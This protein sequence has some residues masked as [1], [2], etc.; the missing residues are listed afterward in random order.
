M[1]E[2]TFE[3][4]DLV[5]LRLQPYMQAYIKRSG[6][7]KLQSRFFGSYKVRRKVGAVAYELELPFGS[8]IHNVFNASC[9]KRELGQHINPIEELPLLD[10]EGQLILIPETM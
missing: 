10:E 3:V 4:G 1:V 8:K 9:L 7:E 2:C 6:I 5:Y